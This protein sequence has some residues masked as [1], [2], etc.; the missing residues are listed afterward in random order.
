MGQHIGLRI[1]REAKFLL[2]YSTCAL[3]IPLYTMPKKTLTGYNWKEIAIPVSKS[4]PKPAGM[5]FVA[6][7]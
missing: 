7:G 5:G 6:G 4:Y 3:R 1:S 2:A